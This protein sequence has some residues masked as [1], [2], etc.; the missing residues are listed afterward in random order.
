MFTLGIILARAGS[1]G[2]TEKCVQPL[3]GRALIEFTF[4]HALAAEH[5]D[6]TVLSTDSAQAA[7]LARRREIEVISRPSALA[8]DSARIDDAARH[9]VE[10]WEQLHGQSIDAATV[11]Y[12]NIPIRAAGAL[13][14][15]IEL[16]ERSGGTSVRS[17]AQ[18]GRHHPDWLHRLDG[19]RL[20]QYRPNSIYRR[21]DLEP[22]YYH[23]GAVIVV[24]RAALF[25]A[26]AQPHNAQ[27]F[28]GDDPRALILAP[29]DAVD[30]DDPIDLLQAESV[31][32]WQAARLE[33]MPVLT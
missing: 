16:L 20:R 23:D 8:T 25:A 14:R 3:L 19:D 30:V 27:A 2:L 33:N 10:T 29:E 32:R 12:G 5:L 18:I 7:A 1:R 26:A 11:L 13:D 24:T 28:W 31:L 9:A 4:D 15:G 17:V 21:Q 6:A 22:L